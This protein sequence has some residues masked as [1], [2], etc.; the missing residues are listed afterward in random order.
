ML[1]KECKCHGVSGSCSLKTC[2]EK[3]PAFRD[4]GDALMKQYTFW[5]H[6]V[7]LFFVIQHG[8][9][10]QHISALNAFWCLVYLRYREAKAVVAKE[11]RSGNDSKPRKLLTLQ[12]RRKPHNKPRISELV[13]LQP[14]PNYCEVDP[15]T[16]SLGVVGRRCN[17]TSAGKLQ[18]AS[19]NG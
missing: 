7:E 2:W 18:T 1:K 12:L 11:S 14:S 6:F 10:G 13:F 16:G 5:I 17:R 8:N 4:I 15:S 3:L 9:D 19:I